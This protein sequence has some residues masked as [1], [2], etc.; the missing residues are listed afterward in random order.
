[1]KLEKYI[2]KKWK[3]LRSKGDINELAKLGDVSTVTV[4][5][6][7]R[8]GECSDNLLTVIGTFYEKRTELIK[9]YI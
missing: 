8:G 4:R 2:T 1:M 6:A 5:A 3:V 7:L 9:Q